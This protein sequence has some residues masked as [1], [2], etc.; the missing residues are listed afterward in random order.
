MNKK[1]V[2][3]EKL[4]SNH[5]TLFK[6]K[7]DAKEIKTGENTFKRIPAHTN[8]RLFIDSFMEKER[9]LH[10]IFN[11]L[12]NANDNDNLE[13][14]INSRG[15]LVNEGSQFYS[16]IKNKFN[17]RTTTI[18]DSCGYSMGALT[19][20]MGDKRVATLRSDLMFHDYSGAIGGKGGEIKSRFKHS[21][22]HLRDFFKD[23]ILKNNFLSQKEFEQ[24]L[25][26]KDFWMDTKELC[27]RG[28]A[29]HV[30]IEGKE[31]KA[32][33]YLKSLKKK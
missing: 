32:K 18:L 24:M 29:T 14:R 6:S 20:C 26:G 7:I 9:G 11:E 1:D 22:K 13:L 8:F 2:K 19:F 28:I 23:V 31:I 30:L 27:K 17:K 21:S 12:W 15:G 10:E 4:N 33:K 16:I 3:D 5:H 25:I